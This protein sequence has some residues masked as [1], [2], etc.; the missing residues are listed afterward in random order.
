M[1]AAPAP[2]GAPG[3]PVAAPEM[4]R[5]LEELGRWRDERRAELDEL[6]RAA[7]GSP[8]QRGA[9]D[10]AGLTGDMTLAMAMWQA[11]ATRTD[12]LTQV[13][14]SGRVGPAELTRLS[15]LVWGRLDP[16]AGSALAVSLPEACRL[17][18]ALTG[19]LRGR[20]ALD[21]M[22]PDV[23]ARL[24]S[25][26]ATLER[27]RDLVAQMPAGATRTAATARFAALDLRAADALDRAKRGADVGGVLGPLEQESAVV[28]RDLI[29]G[30]A[31]RRDDARDRARAQEWRAALA[32]RTPHVQA[33]VDACV[34]AVAPAPV[35][36]VPRV[37]ALGPVPEDA[38]E[39]D[40]YLER[41]ADVERALDRVEQAYRAPVAELGDLG[42]ALDAYRVKAAATGLDARPEVSGMHRLAAD[43]LAQR[44]VDLTRA[45]AAVA[46][47]RT[48][49]DLRG[50]A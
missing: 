12:E 34:A 2:P 22:G 43:V 31:T 4:L 42:A 38:A 6:D 49:I 39:V 45:R 41:L 25:V 29:V 5:F 48:L 1:T 27:V 23:Q 14:D 11:V 40:A 20:L 18:D 36:G 33:A 44:P 8:G 21:P 10:A 47:V 16:T 35:L 26:R 7:L 17:S 19:Q 32:A 13:W 37:E 50:G 15:T 28:E 9:A 46:A 3:R 30:A 24:R